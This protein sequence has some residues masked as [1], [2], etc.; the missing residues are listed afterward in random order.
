MP[1]LTDAGLND[2]KTS[3]DLKVTA[4]L[5]STVITAETSCDGPKTSNL[6]NIC[7]PSEVLM[8]KCLFKITEIIS[9]HLIL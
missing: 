6:H 8:H 2:S 7:T 9:N 1:T 5:K 4:Q 3:A